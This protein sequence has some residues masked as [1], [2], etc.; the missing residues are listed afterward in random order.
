M[1][2]SFKPPRFISVTAR[3]YSKWELFEHHWEQYTMMSATLPWLR[4]AQGWC[5]GWLGFA[6]VQNDIIGL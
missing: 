6:G 2:G 3:E 5:R 1:P 4:F